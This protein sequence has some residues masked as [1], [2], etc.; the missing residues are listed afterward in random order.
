MATRRAWSYPTVWEIAVATD[1]TIVTATA[2][3]HVLRR[4]SAMAISMKR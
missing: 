3:A 2:T 1:E 4:S